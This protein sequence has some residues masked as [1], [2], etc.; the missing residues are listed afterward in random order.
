[1]LIRLSQGYERLSQ[2]CRTSAMKYEMEEASLIDANGTLLSLGI[3]GD[4]AD[5]RC[6]VAE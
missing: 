3:H 2:G 6:R 4:F 1:M 5:A